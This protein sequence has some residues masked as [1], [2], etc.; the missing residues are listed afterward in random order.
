MPLGGGR[1]LDRLGHDGFING[2]EKF[3]PYFGAR[4]EEKLLAL[5]NLDYGN[6]LYVFEENWKAC[7]S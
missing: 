5:E 6:A 3:P 2:R 7:H 1:S 4:F